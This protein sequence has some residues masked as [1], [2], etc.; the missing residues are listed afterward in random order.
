MKRFTLPSTL[1]LLPLCLAG[2]GCAGSA[3]RPDDTQQQEIQA[4]KARIVELQRESAMNQVELAQLRQ[5]MADV[6]ARNGGAPPRPA[7]APVSTARPVSPPKSG[8]RE[9]PKRVIAQRPPATSEPAPQPRREPVRQAVTPAEPIEEVDIALPENEPHP[10]PP[11]RTPP[12]ATVPKAVASPPVPRPATPKVATPA[13]EPVAPSPTAPSPTSPAP[14]SPAPAPANPGE[15]PAAIDPLS[16]ANQALYDRGYTLF[17]QGHYVD[18][19]A[20][21]QRFLQANPKSEL[22]DNAQYW[23]G[24]C[25]YSRNDVKGA[26]AAFREVV[27]KFPKGNKVADAMLKAGQCMEAMGDKEGARVTY[28][29]VNRRFPG[30]VAAAVAEERRAKLP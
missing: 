3:L 2:A 15:E 4:L 28:R 29:E 24:E 22:A 25:R 23:I 5:Q 21:F 10:P 16:P 1:L 13:P 7:P 12:A 30:T 19:E 26:L 17:H 8:A 6:E 11:R 18:A 27:E 14:S 20:S 9:D